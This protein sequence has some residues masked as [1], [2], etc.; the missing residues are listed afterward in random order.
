ML[1]KNLILE[2]QVLIFSSHDLDM[3][4]SGNIIGDAQLGILEKLVSNFTINC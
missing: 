2:A 3:R 1:L 4:G